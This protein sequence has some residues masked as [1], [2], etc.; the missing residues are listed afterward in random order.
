MTEAILRFTVPDLTVTKDDRGL[1]SLAAPKD[2][3]DERIILN[4]ARQ[5]PRIV[6][7]AGGLDVQG[8]AYLQHHSA[9]SGSD[10]YFSGQN[11]EDIYL[12]EVCDLVCKATGAKSAIV[13]NC[14]FRYKLVDEKRDPKFYFK[15]GNP[16]DVEISKMPR[17]VTMGKSRSNEHVLF[18]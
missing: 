4:D 13:N 2:V 1:F 7:G 12:P 15:R 16:I 17:N 8:F 10:Q 18:S 5:D 6:K 11:I 14:A 3:I 9:L